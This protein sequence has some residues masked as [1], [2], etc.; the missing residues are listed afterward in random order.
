MKKE[1]IEELLERL[2]KIEHDQWVE[3]SKNLSE[4][5]K[6]SEDRVN[7]WKKLWVPYDDLTEESK[8]QDRVY[9][10]KVLSEIQSFLKETKYKK[11]KPMTKRD[12]ET[13]NRR[14]NGH[15]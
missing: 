5:E 8:E 11:A 13:H 12:F 4:N 3:W 1:Q 9:A 15:L 14:T 2:S 6:L 10:R 7:R